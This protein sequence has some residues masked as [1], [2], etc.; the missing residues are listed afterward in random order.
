MRLAP[1]LQ[2][3][4]AVIMDSIKK[5]RLGGLIMQ[6]QYWNIWPLS[7]FKEDLDEE[8][9]KQIKQAKEEVVEQLKANAA[10][11]AGHLKT[12]LESAKAK[13][14]EQRTEI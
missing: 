8:G 10:T 1:H 4:N 5:K 14:I 11:F 7:F 9:W 13:A 2:E 12:H 3:I 6:N